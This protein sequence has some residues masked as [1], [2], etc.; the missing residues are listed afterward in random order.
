MVFAETN[1]VCDFIIFRGP[2]HN[3]QLLTHG[4]NSCIVVYDTLH[5]NTLGDLT[6]W[7]SLS[8]S[9]KFRPSPKL[10]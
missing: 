1:S 3:A 9:P 5:C 4:V 8:L 2:N 10:I 6:F 7:I